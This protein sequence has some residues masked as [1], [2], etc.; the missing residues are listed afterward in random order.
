M[1][2]NYKTQ[3]LL[4]RGVDF[5]TIFPEKQDIVKDMVGF[6]FNLADI[7]QFIKVQTQDFTVEN[8]LALDVD[9]HI[10][11]IYQK[12]QENKG[13]DE[14]EKESE[15]ASEKSAESSNE[16]NLKVL[17]TRVKILKGM[18]KKNP[19]NS[20]AKTRLKIV[21]KMISKINSNQ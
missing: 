3:E 14:S 17:Q 20:L 7:V 2:Y 9:K 15:S 12:N 16:P 5:S 10:Y 18:I 1:Q 11:Y 4:E 19:E 13:G 21:E 6:D 8:P